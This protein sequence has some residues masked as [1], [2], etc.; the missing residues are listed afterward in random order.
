MTTTNPGTIHV[1]VVDDD[2]DTQDLLRE[3]LSEEGYHVRTSGSGEDALKIGEQEVFDVII[4]DMKLGTSLNGLDILRAY[5]SIQPESEVILITAFGSM[6]TAIEAVK[7]GAFDYI[8]K[9]FKIDEVLLQVSRAI[10]SR[11]LMRENRNLKRQLG[12]QGQ[13]SSLVGR[14]PAMLEIYKKIA[15]ISDARST[16]LIYGESGTGKELVAKAIH[17]NGARAGQRFFAVN[18][19]ALAESLL[20][21]ELFGHARGSF[22]GAFESKRGILEDAS[23]GT[24]FLDE[25]AEMSASLQVKLLRAIESQEV[26]RIGSNQVIKTDIRFIAASNKVLG[27]LVDEG[28]FRAD[29]YYRLRVVEINIPPLRERTEDIPLLVEYFLKVLGRERN[30]TY[31]VSSQALSAL[32]SYGWPGNVRELEN[33]LEATVALNRS[34]AI[35]LEDLP[36]KVRPGDH[37]GDRLEQL[38]TG[39][40]SLDELAKRYLLHVLKVTGDN[41]ARAAS[42]MGI[43]RKTL[44]RMV[45]RFKLRI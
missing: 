19:G 42:I 11:C 12:S 33:T 14:S 5:K 1:L 29:L 43:D 37:H 26:R 2:P 31:S 40:P 24:V 25:V 16:V 45:E 28:K 27:Q 9:P 20:E 6:E 21:S 8:S 4:S 35:A 32:I 34:G 39:L 3:V 13:L 18:C 41:K 36:Q 10:E 38:H 30:Q 17:H 7:A 22:T 23:G 44:Y 15:M